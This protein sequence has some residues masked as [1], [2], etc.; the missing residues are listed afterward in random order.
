MQCGMARKRKLPRWTQDEIWDRDGGCCS[1]LDEERR[2]LE[3]AGLRIEP[4]GFI[5]FG[6]EDDPC[7]YRLL[8]PAH[9]ALAAWGVPESDWAHA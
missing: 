3:V 1:Y 4:W 6:F 8:C 2:C 7:L 9:A 5:P